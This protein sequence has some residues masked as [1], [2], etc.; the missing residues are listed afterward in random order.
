MK[1]CINK[2]YGGFGLSLKAIERYLELKGEDMYVYH[3]IEHNY[4]DGQD[5][6]IKVDATEINKVNFCYISL[7]D[8]GDTIHD[9]KKIKDSYFYDGD[10]ARDDH[11]LITVVEELSDDANGDFAELKIIEIPDDINWE[12]SEYDGMESVEEVHRSWY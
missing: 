11:D 6:Y 2:C 3:Q 10:I 1:I 8:A 4:R 5:T 7:K 12:I 9:F